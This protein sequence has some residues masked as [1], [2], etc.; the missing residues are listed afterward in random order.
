M[1]VFWLSAEVRRCWLSYEA[2]QG[3]SRDSATD[4]P[5]SGPRLP[6][7]PLLPVPRSITLPAC[8]CV[9]ACVDV[10][11]RGTEPARPREQHEPPQALHQCCRLDEVVGLASQLSPCKE[12]AKPSS[13]RG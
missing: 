1:N 9:R 7:T 3:A 12:T 13:S 2:D 5:E 4:A 6:L 8:V 11:I 10:L